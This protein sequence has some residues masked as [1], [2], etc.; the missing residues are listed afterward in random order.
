MANADATDAVVGGTAVEVPDE[1]VPTMAGGVQDDEVATAAAAVAGLRA[2]NRLLCSNFDELQEMYLRLQERAEDTKKQ[3]VRER[4]VRE[5]AF[6]EHMREK[7]GLQEKLRQREEEVLR[8][9]ADGLQKS[10]FQRLQLQIREELEA[11]YEESIKVLKATAE[12]AR[13]ERERLAR[14]NMQEKAI[15]EATASELRQSLSALQS[16][17][18]TETVLL[19]EQLRNLRDERG[20]NTE[21]HHSPS[22]PTEACLQNPKPR[23]LLAASSSQCREL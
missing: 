19:N 9:R 7:R 2:E 4:D 15:L 12:E 3:L 23:L 5:T 13:L 17:K 1:N 21:D 16:E 14:E 20:T 6:Q 8:I 18:D 22:Q 10:D 11:P